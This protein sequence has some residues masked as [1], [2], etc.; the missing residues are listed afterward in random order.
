MYF[1]VSEMSRVQ[2][3]DKK[4]RTCVVICHWAGEPARH[5]YRL[6]TQLQRTN[7]GS[8]FDTLIVCNGGVE[9]PLVLPAR[10]NGLKAR[11]I[12]RRNEGYNLAAWECG[13]RAAGEYEFFL[14]LQDQCVVR[15]NNWLRDF[16]FRLSNDPGTGLLGEQLA[17]DRM[18]WDYIRKSTERDLGEVIARQ[19]DIYKE[20]LTKA[21]IPLGDNG[22]HLK[23]IILFTSRNI[24]Q[25]IDG[26]PYIGPSYREAVASE[27]GFSRLIES[28]HY[29]IATVRGGNYELIGHLQWGKKGK[30][31]FA[32]KMKWKVLALMKNMFPQRFRHVFKR[33]FPAATRP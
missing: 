10:F 23:S 9:E 17:W 15:K 16:E 14:F 4:P 24:L 26:F 32:Y 21:N 3:G 20:L 22:T 30:T 5:L 19:I 25:E 8:S 7:S 1:G 29:R 13:W 31:S 12:N 2:S 11:I 27:I 6:L 33:L 28:R 18:S